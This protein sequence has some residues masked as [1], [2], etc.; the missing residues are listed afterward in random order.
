[1][2][3]SVPCTGTCSSFLQHMSLLPA[4]VL[5]LVEKLYRASWTRLDGL[6]ALVLTPTRELALQIFEELVK[7]SSSHR[8]SSSAGLQHGT[9]G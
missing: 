9:A 3:F 4:A 8:R 2:L 5:Q 7:V 1:M 6:G